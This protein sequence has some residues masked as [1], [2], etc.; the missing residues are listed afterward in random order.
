MNQHYCL[1]TFSTCLIGK[2][3][4]VIN[5]TYTLLD[6]GDKAYSF[7]GNHLLAIFRFPENYM[8][9]KM[10]LADI[11]TEVEG[12]KQITV[13]KEVHVFQVEYFLGGDWKFLALI[14]GM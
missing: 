7:E 14:N 12:L 2:R 8:S 13:G 4:H 3:L 6:E 5:I 9:L 10:A 1:I 11:I